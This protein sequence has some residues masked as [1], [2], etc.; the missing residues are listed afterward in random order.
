MAD[1]IY[2]TNVTK[3]Y[4]SMKELMDKQ[5][6]KGS[7]SQ[8]SP[9]IFRVFQRLRNMNPTAY[10]PCMVSI[11][12]LH[13]NDPKLKGMHDAKLRS[14]HSLLA[15]T[16]KS[17]NESEP[18]VDKILIKCVEAM[19]RAAPKARACYE[20]SF[21]VKDEEF[22]QMLMVDGCFILEFLYSIKFDLDFEKFNIIRDILLLE[23]QIPFF[24]L[25]RLFEV[26]LQKTNI[27]SSLK[28]CLIKFLNS[29]NHQLMNTEQDLIDI[30]SQVDDT[31]EEDIY[32]ILGLL[33]KLY[34]PKVRNGEGTYGEVGYSATEL[35]K[36]GVNFKVSN[37]PDAL[38]VKFETYCL[39]FSFLT[40]L[41]NM[42]FF[43]L[44][45]SL[46]LSGIFKVVKFLSRKCQFSRGEDSPLV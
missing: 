43:L 7:S 40:S 31:D 9:N 15:E 21:E 38:V 41:L 29:I 14:M 13:S 30:G 11:G 16:A 42:F 26:T 46:C 27:N 6:S 20:E 35:Y 5:Q 19:L 17:E 22:A 25:E 34:R 45:A 8:A 33:Q 2:Q 3:L 39:F 37:A 44:P 4:T 12:P 32:H 18:D 24:I 10:T 36:S 28:Q 23:N 1:E